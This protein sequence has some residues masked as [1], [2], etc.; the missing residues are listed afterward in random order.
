M[1]AGKRLVGLAEVVIGVELVEVIFTVVFSQTALLDQSQS[2]SIQLFVSPLHPLRTRQARPL[3]FGPHPSQWASS[4][5]KD[6]PS[7]HSQGPL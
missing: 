2:K 5:E 7:S 3:S 1:A 4:L 6:R